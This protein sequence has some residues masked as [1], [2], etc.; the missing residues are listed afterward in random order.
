M[1]GTDAPRAARRRLRLWSWLGLVAGRLLSAS[2]LL[3]ILIVG[4]VYL[5]LLAGPIDIA[6]L[7]PMIEDAV[8]DRLPGARLSIGGVKV[9]LIPGEEGGGVAVVATDAALIDDEDGPFARVP[10]LTGRFGLSDLLAGRMAPDNVVLT[11]V[12]GRLVRDLQAGF[13]FGFGGLG[14]DEAGDGAAAFSRLLAAALPEEGGAADGGPALGAGDRRLTLRGAS[15]L[16]LDQYGGRSY[17]AEGAELVFRSDGG[18]L[19]A[20]AEVAL[21]GGRHGRAT[22]TLHGRLTTDGD[23]HL[24]AA[25]ENAAPADIGGQIM[26][27]DW[28]K[29]LDAP[30]G[31][32]INLTL[33]PAGEIVSLSGKLAVG[34]G[35]V[36]LDVGTKEPI[37]SAALDFIY[38]PEAGRFQIAE[39]SLNADRAALAGSGFVQVGRDAEGD[40][41]DVV[42]QLDFTDIRVAAPEILDAPLDYRAARLTGRI[43][44]EPLMIEIGEVRLER[45]FMHLDGAGR[46]WPEDDAWRGEMTVSGG[47]ISLNE[48]IAHWPRRAAPGARVWMLDNM[49]TAMVS[50]ADAVIRLGGATEE[51]KIDFSFHD[52]VGYPLRPMPPVRGGAGSGQVDLKRVSIALDV[53]SVTSEG[54]SAIDLA[55]STFIIADLEHPDTPGEA[56]VVARGGIADALALI[57]EEPLGLISKL[58]VP[59]GDVA[60]QADIVATVNLPLLKDL[61]LEDVA[62]S[63]VASLSNVALVAPGLQR[64]VTADALALTASTTEFNLSGD[65]VVASIPASIEWKEVFSPPA[66][67]ITA[68]G[69]LTPE[70]LAKFGVEQN[71]FTRGR[72]PVTATLQPSASETRFSLNADLT[73]GGVAIPEIGWEKET[74]AKG[75]LQAAGVLAGN[76]LALD[77]FD[78]NAGDFSAAG[79]ARTDAAGAVERVALSRIRFREAVDLALTAE[80][81][82][83]TWRI[84]AEGPLLDLT[85]L[86]DLIDDAIADGAGAPRERGAAVAPFR[87]DAKIGRL[88]VTEDYGFSDVDGFLRRT[89]SD[90]VT[91][92]AAGSVGV[93]GAPVTAALRRDAAG[94][95]LRLEVKDAGRFLRD[96]KV[97]DDGAGGD[98]L[99][100]ADIAKGSPLSLSGDIRVDDIVIHKDAKLEQMLEGAELSELHDTMRGDGIVFDTIRAPFSYSE[101][102]VT[103]D[104]AVAKGPSIGVNVSGEY[105]LDADRLDLRGVF[106]PLYK[107]NSA[108]GKIPLIGSVLTGG[109]GQGVFAFTFAVTGGADSPKVSVNPLSV[110]TPG[111]MR[112]IFEAGERVEG[113]GVVAEPLSGAENER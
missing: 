12:S 91:A 35:H 11:G 98:L 42:A 18:E 112:R 61:L 50:E 90:E 49:E 58:G 2:L 26:A 89:A 88:Q 15:I 47:S 60:G 109:D 74:G 79:S 77:S 5:R 24:A 100:R 7:L 52:A 84:A 110:L 78:L 38:E 70:R 85:R 111:V 33:N 17:R 106:T 37:F 107:L 102:K 36:D 56:K 29:A 75:A 82:K 14:D 81:D 87:I 27:L 32:L 9:A 3:T 64:E 72:I 13:R 73:A 92:R 1:S 66:R 8:S 41:E 76:R 83:R 48:L 93:G 44:L 20:D 53:G 43:T 31:G 104:D 23:I 46:L 68:I 103:L 113:D 54:R 59:L 97:F 55:G 45:E 105:D 65:V 40:P 4:G 71:W 86:E 69:D 10:E 51:V 21:V 99:L 28:M 30:V 108:L 19:I 63:A 34:G 16:Y 57:D 80:R 25:F 101:D 39:V 22:A 94:G 95:L 62:A 67:S 6:P 96:I